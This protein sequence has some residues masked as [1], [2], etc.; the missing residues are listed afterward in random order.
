MQFSTA[1]EPLNVVNVLIYPCVKELLTEPEQAITDVRRKL[2]FS[3]LRA[4]KLQKADWT[5]SL[6]HMHFEVCSFKQ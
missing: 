4:I 6:Q 1:C 2:T 3:I 5:I